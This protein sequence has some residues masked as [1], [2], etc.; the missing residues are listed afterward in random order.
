MW[1]GGRKVGGEW[2]WFDNGR[3]I[4]IGKIELVLHKEAFKYCDKITQNM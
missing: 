3:T 4:V 2:L 1:F